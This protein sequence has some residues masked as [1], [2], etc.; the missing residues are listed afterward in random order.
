MPRLLLDLLQCLQQVSSPRLS[1]IFEKLK[2]EEWKDV[3][4]ERIG[5]LE[6]LKLS[7]WLVIFHSIAI[8]FLS[9][10][11]ARRWFLKAK[12]S[13][14][15]RPTLISTFIYVAFYVG[16]GI[17]KKGQAWFIRNWAL[18]AHRSWRI[19]TM[20]VI[21]HFKPDPGCRLRFQQIATLRFATFKSC[22]ATCLRILHID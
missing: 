15:A 12:I 8:L 4:E 6:S 20:S 19:R 7:S 21:R 13:S 2:N 9:I 3:R 18:I 16:R 11:K 22:S 5:I 10:I 1:I 14:L 17:R